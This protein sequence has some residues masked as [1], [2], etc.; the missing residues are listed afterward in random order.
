M[1]IPIQVVFDCADPA[2]LA[3]FWSSA[4]DYVMQPPPAGFGSW[5]EFLTSQG[6]PPERFN[7]R[8][9]VVDP[10]GVGPRI[11]F[12][13]VPE[14]KTVKNRVH[15]DVNVGTGLEPDAHRVK[16]AATVDRLVGEGASVVQT[17]DEGEHWVVLQ[18]PEG[19]EF[20]VQ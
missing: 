14:P 16:V 8:S 11:F 20:C 7:D 9:A 10:T 4:L 19:N 3:A 13:K 15:V 12:Q 6:F 17:F 5:E 2:R 18:D 1:A